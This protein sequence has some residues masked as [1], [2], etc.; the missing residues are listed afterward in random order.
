MRR[1][2]LLIG[3]VALAGTGAG[4]WWQRRHLLLEPAG[5]FLPLPEPWPAEARAD[6]IEIHKVEIFA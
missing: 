4:L 2:T 6:R 3:G 1:R 5:E